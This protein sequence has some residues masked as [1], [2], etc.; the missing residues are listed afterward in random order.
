[1]RKSTLRIV[2]GQ[3]L[4]FTTLILASLPGL[5]TRS[6]VAPSYLG[7]LG[8]IPIALGIKGLWDSNEDDGVNI[9]NS[10][11]L[12]RS[13]WRDPY[14]YTVAG[15]TIGNG[16]DNIAIYLSFFASQTISTLSMTLT[17]FYL[18][19]AGWC[20]AAYYLNQNHL[21]TKIIDRFSQAIVPWIFILLG[22]YILVSSGAVEF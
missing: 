1:L 15:I 17:I 12:D 4:G 19:M 11:H 14:T 13:V 9:I 20:C 3:Y 2:I 22:L 8:L 7:W 18:M 5:L 10:P 21:I 6:I 16:G